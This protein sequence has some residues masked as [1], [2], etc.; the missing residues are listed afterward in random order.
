MSS[1]LFVIE[2]QLATALL[3]QDSVLDC[4]VRLRQSKDLSQQYLVVYV[5]LLGSF[6]EQRLKS[7]LWPELQEQSIPDVQIIPITHVPLL[8][9][10]EIDD[11]A[12]AQ[13]SVLDAGLSK[14]WQQ[15]WQSHP[16]V[17]QVAVTVEPNAV[18]LSR[19]HL[20]E[21][22]PETQLTRKSSVEQSM[23]LTAASNSMS[24]ETSEQS[25]RLSI[26]RGEE[27]SLEQPLP[28][29]LAQALQRTAQTLP[30]QGITYIRM[31]GTEQVQTYPELLSQAK[32]ILSGLQQ[33]GIKPQEKIIF[34]FDNNQDYIPAFW[35]CMLGGFVPV[36][37]SIAPVYEPGNAVVQKLCN[38]W[39]QLEKPLIFTN[40]QVGQQLKK[41]VA[42]LN[43]TALRLQT[44]ESLAVSATVPQG[45]NGSLAYESQ[46]DDLAVLLFTSG[47]T[48]KP[49]GVCLTHYNILSN[50]AASAQVNQFTNQD[51]SLNWLRLD[52]VGSLVRCSIRDIYV[53]SHQVHAPAEL[54]LEQP[55]KL[56]DWI[57]QYQVTF[58]W[59]P[60]FALG[61]INDHADEI[62][63]RKWD[64]SSLRS[65]LSVAE[66]IVPRTA[67]RF[68][69]LLT[70]FG[71]TPEKMHA[72]WGMS[73]TCA[74]VTFSHRYL[75][76][77]APDATAVEVG[78]PTAG[79]QMRVVDTQ[80]QPLPEN[81]TGRLQIQGPMVLSGYYEDDVLNQTAFTHDGW[82]KTGDLG[83]L[84]N[85][86]LTVTGR[87]KDVI[88]INGLNHYS[89]EIEAVVEAVE[90]VEVSYTVACGIRRP[91][92]NTDLL[93]VFFNSAESHADLG[94]LLRRIRSHVV[95]SLGISPT[96]LIP[97][98]KAEVPKT[99]I[100]K[101][102]RLK[103]KQQFEAG[104]FDQRIKQADILLENEN[105]I[106]D[107]F[108]E[109]V[110]VA[111]AANLLCP[112][113]KIGL[114][115]IFVDR[116]GLG[117]ALKDQLANRDAS[118]VS[119]EYVLVETGTEFR[120]LTA[121]R[122]SLNPH[123]AY[124]YEQ[125][126]AA[127][128]QRNQPITQIIHCWQYD[129]LSFV[130]SLETLTAAQDLGLYSVLWLIQAL[131]SQS[132][133]GDRT[134]RLQIVA[135]HAQ[136][137]DG[138][139]SVAYAKSP[140]L[141][142]IKTVSK[143]IPWL[144]CRHLDLAVASAEE[145]AAYVLNELQ[146]LQQD[147]E[148]AVRDG[149]RR[150]PRLKPVR[151]SDE[152]CQDIP[153][154]PE[155]FYVISG[156]LG[157]VAVEIAQYLMRHYR[158]RLL[159][160]GR[161]P[162]PERSEWLTRVNA[163]DRTAERIQNLMKLE[164]IDSDR[165]HY[166]AVDI[167]DFS[168]LLAVVEQLETQ[169][170]VSLNG[171]FHLA[172]TAPER[173]LLEES[174]ALLADTLR[175]KM[176]GTWS[177]HQ[178]AMRRNNC[179]F[180]SLS[181]V[182]SVFGGSMVGGYAVANSFL[183]SFSQYQRCE[184]G[185][186]SYCFGSSTW[187]QI[188]VNK[189]YQGADARRAQ[190]QMAM[191]VQQGLDS[192]L[193]GL[194]YRKQQLIFGLDGTKRP[195]QCLKE[196]PVAP[197]H[198]F[199]AYG[200]LAGT[201]VHLQPAAM[202]DNRFD[203]SSQC[204]FT[205]LP[206]LP[207]TAAGELDREGLS[208]LLALDNLGRVAPR[209]AVEQ[210]LVEIWQTVLNV[211]SVGIGDNFFE[212]GG[213]SVLAA[214]LFLQIEQSFDRVLPLATLFQAPTVEQ[215]AQVISQSETADSWSSL[216]PIH[217][218]GVNTPL[219]FVHAGFGDIVCFEKLVRYLE[220]DRPFYALRPKDLDGVT[221]PLE[222]IEAMAAYYVAE[223]R[224]HQPQGP[225]LLGGQCTGGIVAYEMARQL[226]QKGHEVELLVML[227]TT[228]PPYKNYWLP[229]LRYYFHKPAF[230]PGSLDFWYNAS[231]LLYLW[232]K[233]G[234]SIEY[235]TRSIRRAKWLKRFPALKRYADKLMDLLGSRSKTTT[236]SNPNGS[237]G[238]EQ[239]LT[240]ESA[241]GSATASSSSRSLEA[242]TQRNAY[243][244]D[245]F[246]E[247]FLR[248]QAAYNPQPYDGDVDFLLSTMDTY[249]PVAKPYSIASFKEAINPVTDMDQLLWGWDTLVVKEFRVHPFESP[250]EAMMD[251][252]YVN[253]LVE[254]LQAVID[255]CHT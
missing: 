151:F 78:A 206:E 64:L 162:L 153:I 71:L 97:V 240:D 176:Q 7:Y 236:I 4:V 233:V 46:P 51:I 143:E 74:A 80:D 69:E 188:G 253:R 227:D 98:E 58:A 8:D 10:G 214:R 148:V 218:Q 168:R 225:Y 177:L 60:N 155:G 16:D 13:L 231:L 156:G 216:V 190:G 128:S 194:G 126:L 172:G 19:L 223:V 241:T 178:L 85:G 50:V 202:V 184:T 183:E 119:S 33:L 246:F 116:L 15:Y 14:R 6:N 193:I 77:L 102:Q 88:I 20:S 92:Q 197:T 107:W 237:A 161:S 243:V 108:Y 90:G 145:N 49:K 140:L 3:R 167:C 254:E 196:T 234:Y 21:V 210:E 179:L 62:Q 189:G 125:L 248:A 139:E 105:T 81:A 204:E 198:H 70:P 115:L 100:G 24:S 47:S 224:K 17:D 159:L 141:G 209:N 252:P 229:R 29:N 199:R 61:L 230:K 122:Y 146:V 195:V 222:T 154:Q 130:D 192:L 27:L 26:A 181:S 34:Q 249:V 96:Y 5:V 200:T 110:W 68:T 55:L 171:I 86:R 191:S 164:A 226:K 120:Q 63:R 76:A 101:L 217:T 250:H 123:H 42:E 239:G 65:M 215:L 175:P 187:S 59:A 173:L 109:K 182:L 84:S 83:Y 203:T 121:E 238:L 219:F 157:G 136:A 180:V 208:K 93:L 106:P 132:Q 112:L 242:V 39:E 79:F 137:T 44:L 113:T 158:T 160:L 163:E 147:Q 43:L 48:G 31:D 73:E 2:H 82:F 117:E 9:N 30:T 56:L 103:L 185:L 23:T 66:A 207:L 45:A 244:K 1:H 245:R 37:I 40:E 174:Q 94:S 124:H 54:V 22:L 165:I 18:P 247:T 41:L 95:R 149:Y 52:H 150:V 133:H 118:S 221:E 32:H 134:I 232:R 251:E 89:H 99:S 25:Q 72:A 166:E 213:T 57:E 12:L 38:T 201:T 114:T 11:A 152:Q 35:A 144:D 87:E 169:W 75:L 28:L 135:S 255:N 67:Q 36:P 138:K 142:L 111:K 131:A 127:L 91:G 211:D 104:Q 53:G 129:K 205:A 228:F 170:Q 220:L 235:R 212:L 186:Q